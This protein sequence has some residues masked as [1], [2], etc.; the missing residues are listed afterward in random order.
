M[1]A[2]CKLYSSEIGVPSNCLMHCSCSIRMLVYVVKE[3]GRFEA[4]EQM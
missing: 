4:E 2:G 3:Y 1:L